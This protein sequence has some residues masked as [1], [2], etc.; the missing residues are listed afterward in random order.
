MG[1]VGSYS[2]YWALMF[3]I[4]ARGWG[5][6]LLKQLMTAHLDMLRYK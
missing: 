2:Q 1:I 6:E 4:N 5:L 3:V